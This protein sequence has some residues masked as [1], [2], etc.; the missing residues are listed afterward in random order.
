MTLRDSIIAAIAERGPLTA[1][2]THAFVGST[3]GTI[4][5]MIVRMLESRELRKAGNTRPLKY[6]L[7]EVTP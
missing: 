6:A 7:P 2:E 3:I 5:V 1:A 4:R